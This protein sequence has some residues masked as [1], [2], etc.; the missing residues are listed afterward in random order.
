[1]ACRTARLRP[2][3]RPSLASQRE[4]QRR[5]ADAPQ[6]GRGPRSSG[7][8]RSKAARSARSRRKSR[9]R[10]RRRQARRQIA[11]PTLITFAIRPTTSSPPP[12]PRGRHTARSPVSIAQRAP[13]ISR[14]RSGGGPFPGPRWPAGSRLVGGSRPR[15]RGAW[16]APLQARWLRA[17]GPLLASEHAASSVSSVAAPPDSRMRSAGS[18]A[19]PREG[20]DASVSAAGIRRSASVARPLEV[21]ATRSIGHHVAEHAVVQR[22]PSSRASFRGAGRLTPTPSRAEARSQPAASGVEQGAHERVRADVKSVEALSP[23]LISR[24]KGRASGSLALA[25]QRD[26]HGVACGASTTTRVSAPSRPLLCPQ[27]AEPHPEVAARLEVRRP[28]HPPAELGEAAAARHEYN[29]CE[30]ASGSGRSCP[31]GCPS[32]LRPFQARQ[33]TA[34]GRGPDEAQELQEAVHSSRTTGFRAD[35]RCAETVETVAW[36]PLVVHSE[37]PPHAAW[38]PGW[39]GSSSEW[40]SGLGATTP[41]LRPLRPW[42]SPPRPI[43]GAGAASARTL[44]EHELEIVPVAERARAGHG[45]A[46]PKSGFVGT[47]SPRNARRLHLAVFASCGDEGVIVDDESTAATRRR[48][49]A[50]PE[51]TARKAAGRAAALEARASTEHAGQSVVRTSRRRGP[52]PDL[53]SS[54]TS[55]IDVWVAQEVCSAL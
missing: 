3:L 41:R 35:L 50:P 22:P 32:G 31:E 55:S 7:T 49:A 46:L 16:T 25:A 23:I 42:C 15:S 2:S 54:T 52:S 48:R 39:G 21:L 19:G 11:P 43:Q 51:A 44:A 1:M 6:P 30:G 26:G 20:I 10:P 37:A 13:R 28:R 8:S 33:R 17:R 40:A 24:A 14:T 53:A 27:R 5:C 12:C 29:G 34:C 18:A 9:S 47:V 45:V 36:P 38:S 4:P